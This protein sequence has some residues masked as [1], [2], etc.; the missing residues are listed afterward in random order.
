M[1]SGGVGD[2]LGVHLANHYGLDASH[3]A[4]LDVGVFRVDFNNGLTWVARAFAA[5]QTAE[6]ERDAAVLRALEA[7][8]FP[9]ERCAH[10]DP[11]SEHEGVPVLVT[12]WVEGVPADGRGRTFAILGVLL[13]RLN[14]HRAESMRSGGAWHHLSATGGPREEIDA[15][16]AV[17]ESAE[18]RVPPEQHHL[19]DETREALE[20][21]DDCHDLPHAF[22]HPDFVPANALATPDGGRVIIDW[23]GTGN[24]PRL[25]P[26]AF[27]LWA[28]GVRD[29]R[30]VDAAFSRY[31]RHISLEPEELERLAA[32]IP[33]RPLTMDVWSFG[34][35]RI[36][37]REVIVRLRRNRI[38]AD[39]ISGHVRGKDWA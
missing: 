20:Y 28:G 5:R 22:V 6:V 7:S 13:G 33:S 11:V 29:L 36:D 17:L 32:V 19:Y 30:L 15:A 38:A 4:A 8:G 26:L 21:L 10:D 25:W 18:G 12:R 2:G 9:A 39:R 37:L 31:T 35:G 16:I 34:N 23:A 24:G 14:S 3:I 1:A 27:L